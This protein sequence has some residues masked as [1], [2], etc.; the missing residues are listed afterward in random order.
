MIQ[1]LRIIIL[2]ISITTLCYPKSLISENQ[3][4]ESIGKI[5]YYKLDKDGILY[6]D[7]GDQ[8]SYGDSVRI[9]LFI[10][11]GVASNLEDKE[12]FG[13]RIELNNQSDYTLTYEKEISSKQ[14]HSRK[15]W[16][17]TRAG[18]WFIDLDAQDFSKI[19]VKRKNKNNKK[20][21]IRAQANKIDRKKRYRYKKTFNTIN[22]I[23]KTVITTKSSDKLSYFYKLSNPKKP[24]HFEINGPTTFRIVTRL[25]NPSEDSKDNN[26]TIFVKENGEDIGTYFFNTELSLESKVK[27]SGVPVGKWRSCWINVPKGKHYYSISKGKVSD[28]AVYIRLKEYEAR[29]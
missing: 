5:E 28:N 16:G 12:E 1:L 21:I 24:K 14:K 11:C 4:V 29:K 15:G 13:V 7:I 17:W 6:D 26:Y 23:K 3:T 25:E 22:E 19:I 27:S 20:I 10:R 2:G 8:F 18:V 9:K